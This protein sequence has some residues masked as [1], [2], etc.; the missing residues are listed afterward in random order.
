MEG[1]IAKDILNVHHST[2]CESEEDM[3]EPSKWTK[4]LVVKLLDVTHG[5]WLYRNVHVH[6]AISGTLEG[7]AA[8][9]D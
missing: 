4:S 5:Q 8:G 1:M 6:D 7:R 3:P 9:G 2:A